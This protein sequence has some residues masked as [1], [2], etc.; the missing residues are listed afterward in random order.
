MIDI[1]SFIN[2]IGTLL[3]YNPGRPLVFNSGFFLFL[4]LFFLLFH[5]IFYRNKPLRIA[6]ITLFSLYFYYK[7]TGFYFVFLLVTSIID[8]YLARMIHD[9][10]SQGWR[11][12]Y[13]IASVASNILLLGYFKYTNFFI[14]II[15]S[16]SN[17]DFTNLEIFLPVGI[18]FYTF[19]SLSYTI[20]VYKNDIKPLRSYVNFCFCVS[21]F[22]HLVAGP[23]IRASYII[24]QI[25]KEFYVSKEDLGK[26]L[27]LIIRGLLKKTVADYIGI[28]FV[29]RVFEEPLR[30]SGVE[31][32]LSTYL[33]AFQI[34]GD[35]SGYTDM[36]MGIAQLTGF[37]LP[38]NFDSPYK[39]ASMTEFWRRWH[40]SLSTWL[41]DYVY[42]PLGGNRH[43][44]YRQYF[45]LITTMLLVGLWHG[46]AWK[47]VIWGGMHGLVLIVEKVFDIPAILSR[48]KVFRFA[49]ILI[50]F[51]LVC[52]S[53]I[54]FRS[55]S[56]GNAFDMLNQ[57]ISNFRMDI[58]P[59]LIGGY[60]VILAFA[61]AGY[62]MHFLP[63]SFTG[64]MERQIIR[65]P[66]LGKIAVLI[67][68]IFLVMQVRNS[69]M[70]TFIYFQF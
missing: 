29:D 2:K 23:I 50:T 55:A 8:F 56:F 18:S 65:M 38:V 3:I 40:I 66:V 13:L 10:R 58:F 39:S 33:Y 15:N 60:K 69:D 14:D 44:K 64:L 34:Y 21:F 24:P 63:D 67:F 49:G 59:Q 28:N 47:F 20:D 35:F 4:F 7:S 19:Q 37:K 53:W 17:N 16:L 12:F 9:S 22:P 31:N 48:S 54:F 42:I 30:Y 52:F 41:R 36:A 43:G 68:I 51:H 46:A 62:L 57:I 32:L 61:L 6:Y 5:Q 45:N 27:F 11:K 1:F 70:Q 26:G 25:D